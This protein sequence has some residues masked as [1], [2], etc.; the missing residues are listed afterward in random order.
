MLSLGKFYS[1]VNADP[2]YVLQQGQSM[3]ILGKFYS[4]VTADP[5]YVLQ[6]RQ[7]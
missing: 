5:R 1:K 6:Q 3:L 7:C 2:R 4:K